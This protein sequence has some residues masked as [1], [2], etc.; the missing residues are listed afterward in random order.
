M[1]NCIRLVIVRVRQQR[2]EEMRAMVN[3]FSSSSSYL[4]RFAARRIMH[5]NGIDG[6]A[7]E[8]DINML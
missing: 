7:Q 4:I 5:G 6:R 8:E 1:A 3:F 2:D